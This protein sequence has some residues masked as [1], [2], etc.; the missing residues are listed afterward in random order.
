MCG[1][2]WK[3]CS[4]FIF[5]DL[6][7]T[8]AKKPQRT[9]LA[10]VRLSFFFFLISWGRWNRHAKL[11]GCFGACGCLYPVLLLP[12]IQSQRLMDTLSS[13]KLHPNLIALL[14][15]FTSMHVHDGSLIHHLC[16]FP[17]LSIAWETDKEGAYRTD[18]IAHFNLLFC[19]LYLV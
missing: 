16:F 9:S 19:F 17:S 14:Q 11:T 2:V 15:K 8:K 10:Y 13:P 5:F 12:V 1:K 3:R 7:Y 6:L 18:N 4:L